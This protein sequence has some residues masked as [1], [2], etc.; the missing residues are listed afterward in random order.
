MDRLI[1]TA[2]VDA[3]PLFREGFKHA[4]AGTRLAVVAEGK[5]VGDAGRILADERPDILLL[6]ESVLADAG[7]LIDVLVPARSRTRIVGLLASDGQQGRAGKSRDAV[8]WYVSKTNDGAEFLRAIEAIH[9]GEPF[10]SSSIVLHS[11]HFNSGEPA[12]RIVLSVTRS[13]SLRE[14]DRSSAICRRA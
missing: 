2:I 8:A 9:H 14:S 1:R 13:A 12:N 7:E 4:A 5:T 10:H 3:H 11:R 6:D